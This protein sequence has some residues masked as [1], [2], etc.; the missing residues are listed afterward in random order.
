[1]NNIS[2]FHNLNNFTEQLLQ[3]IN[4]REYKKDTRLLINNNS[5]V[6]DYIFEYDNQ[7]YTLEVKYSLNFDVYRK[8]R[9]TERFLHLKQ[10]GYENII[11][12]YTIVDKNK[13]SLFKDTATILDISNILYII[14]DNI[15]LTNEL[16]NIIDFS[17]ENIELKKPPINIK[18]TKNTQLIIENKIDNLTSINTG[19]SSFKEYQNYCYNTQKYLFLDYLDLWEKQERTEENLNVFD[20]ICK[21][22]NNVVNE[23]YNTV[24]KYF[25]S[26]YIIFE[27]KNYEDKITQYEVC[28]TEKYLYATA[29]R[30]VAIIL[31]RKG[32]NKNG[33]TMIKGILRENGKLIIVLDDEDIKEM[34]K[35]KEEGEDP[36]IILTNKLDYLLTH[37]EK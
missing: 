34:I 17:V 32:I 15:P 12:V 5:I 14:K 7:K 21:I 20:L 10:A 1:M 11:I 30:K 37:L 28:T 18:T 31:T 19:K 26:K 3:Y 33:Y 23:F 27:F 25:N 35:L 16:L 36:T 6:P 2:K 22:K 9:L 29:L 4:I 8:S 24:E 13:K